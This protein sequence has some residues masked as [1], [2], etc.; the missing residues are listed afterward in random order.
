MEIAGITRCLQTL[1]SLRATGN[2]VWP[3]LSSNASKSMV[4]L[5]SGCSL[6]SLLCVAVKDRRKSSIL[7]LELEISNLRFVSR[8]YQNRLVII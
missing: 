7:Y 3:M 8:A 1:R 4:Q 6:L 2:G 5:R